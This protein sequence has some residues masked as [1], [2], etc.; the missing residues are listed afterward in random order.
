LAA[1]LA[2]SLVACVPSNPATLSATYLASVSEVMEVVERAADNFV[3][4]GYVF[5]AV[6]RNNSLFTVVVRSIPRNRNG[7]DCLMTWAFTPSS[8]TRQ[9]VV[10]VS[11]SNCGPDGSNAANRTFGELSRRFRQ[12]GG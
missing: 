1:L 5:G 10:S 3:P 11:Q 2:L 9:T 8:Q 7:A 6:A 12:L 4:E